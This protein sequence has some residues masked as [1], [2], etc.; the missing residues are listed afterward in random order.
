M[1]EQDTHYA[2]QYEGSDAI[3]VYMA[4]AEGCSACASRRISRKDMLHLW[5]AQRAAMDKI[6]ANKFPHGRFESGDKIEMGHPVRDRR[7]L[8]AD[9]WVNDSRGETKFGMSLRL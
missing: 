9:V 6:M 1:M 2:V 4:C 3:S 7:G 8:F 5:K